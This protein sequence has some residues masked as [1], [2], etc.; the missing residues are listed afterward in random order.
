MPRVQAESDGLSVVGAQAAMRAENEE[1]GIKEP[2][3]VPT[4]AGALGQA[5]EISRRLS[6][7]HLC[8]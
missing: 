7:Q 5:E 4:H 2:C 1:F 8:G 3:R 6:E